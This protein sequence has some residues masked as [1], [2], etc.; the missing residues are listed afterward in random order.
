VTRALRTPAAGRRRRTRASAVGRLHRTLLLVLVAGTAGLALS[1]GAGAQEMDPPRVRLQVSSLT[2]VLG[3]GLVAP[4]EDDTLDPEDTPDPPTTLEIRVLVENRSETRIDAARLVV[5]VYPPVESRE[6]LR[7]AMEGD[8]TADPILVDDPAIRDG[9]LG[10]GEIAGATRSFEEDEV[11]WGENGGVHPIR[12]AV[13]RG[14]VVLDEVLTSVVWLQDHPSEPIDTVF[15]WPLDE[16]PWRSAGGTYPAGVDRSILTGE[17]LDN[18]VR[19]LERSPTAPIVLAPAPHLLED[20]RDRANGF[21]VIEPVTQEL[22]QERQVVPEASDARRANDLL[23]RLRE[24]AEG[25][26]YAPVTGSYAGADLSALHATGERG[27]RDLASDAA[28]AGRQ[29]LQTELG[30][31]PEGATHLL[32]GG[33]LPPVLDLIPG[34]QLLVPDDATLTSPGD[35]GPAAREPIRALRSP[36]GRS[37]V[38]FVADEHLSE[39]VTDPTH[40]AGPHIGVQRIVAESA[41][42]HLER[43][44]VSGRSLLL[45]PAADWDPGL[46]TGS[47]LL[48]QLTG[49]PWLELGDVT[50][51]IASGRRAT[52]PVELAEPGDGTFPATFSAELQTALEELEAARG[53]LPEDATAIADRTPAELRDAL[54]RSTSTWLRSDTQRVAQGLVADVRGTLATFLG[55]VSVSES[56]V[57]LTSDVG[58]IPVTL[59][60]TSGEPILVQVEVASQGSLVWEEGRRSQTLLLTEDSSVTVAFP[61]RALSTGIHPV[62]V[63]VTDPSGVL[64][65]Y[66]TTLTVR[67]TAI[68]GPALAGITGVVVVLLLIGALRRR[69]TTPTLSVV[70]VDDGRPEPADRR[71]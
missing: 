47:I 14:T 3:P 53:M 28:A 62:T 68:S 27:P 35:L 4:P 31:S 66:E 19:V 52:T 36:A 13:V 71:Y 17:R 48:A 57:Q 50:T 2:G 33:V 21:T 65:L 16:E 22:Q 51:T 42:L 41:L 1:N 54:M 44:G 37:L 64:A 55:E 23:R 63:K 18:L 11:A 15:V 56:S 40:R 69:R 49:V 25:L 12:I 20:L 6:D 5:E 46:E 29:R 43:P 24:L 58:Q 9:T 61:T 30:R 39:L 45:L 59:Q 60:R 8:L 32:S 34:D 67:S 7:A 70:G 10:V 38:A 26:P